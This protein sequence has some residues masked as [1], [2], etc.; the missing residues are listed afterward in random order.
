MYLVR[1]I[2]TPH[3]VFAAS[4]S[5]QVHS[6]KLLVCS[7]PTDDSHQPEKTLKA[8]VFGSVS[9]SPQTSINREPSAP[10]AAA[11]GSLES[12]AGCPYAPM[13]SPDT[14]LLNS[15]QEWHPQVPLRFTDKT[16]K[17]DSLGLQDCPG[18]RGSAHWEGLPMR[19]LEPGVYP[20]ED[21]EG[22]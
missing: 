11:E 2:R 15:Q 14:G 9:Y 3:S 20:G 8:P 5:Q 17:C 1:T 4:Q 21:Q 22:R 13:H 6:G 16:R 12:E 10:S 7:S 19:T 18:D